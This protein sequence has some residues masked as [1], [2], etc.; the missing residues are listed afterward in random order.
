MFSKRAKT[1]RLWYPKGMNRFSLRQGSRVISAGF[2][3]AACASA[4]S[5]EKVGGSVDEA[6]SSLAAASTDA[7]FRA[8]PDPVVFKQ[9][10][11]GSMAC[12]PC[13]LYNALVAGGPRHRAAARALPGSSHEEK[14]RALIAGY[15]SVPSEVYHGKRSRYDAKRG[16]TSG[17][18]VALANDYLSQQGAPAVEGR[19]LNRLEDETQD[20]QLRRVH[21]A[22]DSAA[23]PPVIEVRSFHADVKEKGDP[24]W[25]GLFGHFL[26]VRAVDPLPESEAA[27]GFLMHCADSYTGRMIPVFASIERFRPYT[28]TNGF[29]VDEKGKEQWRWARN[30]P[31][32]LLTAPDLSLRTQRADWYERSFMALT[33]G[34]F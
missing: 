28:A 8:A 22:F 5:T 2:L 18:L 29:T 14:V 16:T 33:W 4:P 10:P 32:L 30:S 13:S 24:L 1:S 21:R 25:E 19:W 11:I 26:V 12:G 6:G 3:L 7:A 17:D 31:Y 27:S 23:L 15:G 34:L 9:G 20:E